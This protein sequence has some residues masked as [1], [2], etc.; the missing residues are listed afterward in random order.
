MSLYEKQ[1]ENYRR[2]WAQFL[3]FK[4]EDAMSLFVMPTE[5][6]FEQQYKIL[7][8]K[9]KKKQDAG[10]KIKNRSDL[11]KNQMN[12]WNARYFFETDSFNYVAYVLGLDDS[13]I[14]RTFDMI[15]QAITLEKKL[16][17]ELFKYG[18]ELYRKKFL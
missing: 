6:T 18:Q 4:I 16:Y 17:E 13:F 14:K 1:T 11:M 12:T 5:K 7:L 9:F 8:K 3:M 15:Q 10:H 2:F